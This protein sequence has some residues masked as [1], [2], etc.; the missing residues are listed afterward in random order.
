M[1]DSRREIDFCVRVCQRAVK[2]RSGDDCI[3]GLNFSFRVLGWG[4][5]GGADAQ[6]EEEEGRTEDARRASREA[7]EE[8]GKP[9]NQDSGESHRGNSR[10]TAPRPPLC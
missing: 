8:H 10:V 1:S 3:T 6:G 4:P 7:T 5:R 2:W 9:I